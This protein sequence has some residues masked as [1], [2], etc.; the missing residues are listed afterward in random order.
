[1]LFLDIPNQPTI[2]LNSYKTVYDL[3]EKRS[4]NYSDRAVRLSDQLYVSLPYY[5]AL[6]HVISTLYRTG[7][8]FAVSLMPYGTRWRETRRTFHQ[9]FNQE[10]VKRN[11][12]EVITREIRLFL[13]RAS[14]SN[15]KE[16]LDLAI[17]GR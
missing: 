6:L 11:H 4:R 3:M 1:M 15:D 14:Q 9:H 13:Q 7:W 17:V 16:R 2:V 10:A 8:D 5:L 12:H